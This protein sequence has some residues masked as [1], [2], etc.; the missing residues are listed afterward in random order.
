M[1]MNTS[2]NSYTVSPNYYKSMLRIPD[3]LK[4]QVEKLPEQ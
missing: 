3:N 2:E 1:E 4:R